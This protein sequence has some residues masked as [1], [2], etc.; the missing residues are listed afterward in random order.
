MRYR[1]LGKSGLRVSELC[2]GTLN[3]GEAK[4]WGVDGTVAH[5]ILTRFADGG[6]TFIDTAP[7]YAGGEA[8]KIVGSFVSADRS[9]YVIATKYTASL[10]DHPLAG[11]NSRK[12]MVRSVDA[13]LERLGSEYIDVLWLHFWDGTTPLEEILRGVDDLVS[14]GKVL[15]FGFSDTPAWLVSRAC[16]IAEWRGWIPP[17]SIQLEYN[18]AARTPERELLPMAEALDLGKVC[19]APLAAG[20]LAGGERRRLLKM[21]QHLATAGSALASISEAAHRS[22]V[23][24]ALGWL[25]ARGCIPLV[26]ARTIDQLDAIISDTAPLD[27]DILL[28]LDSIAEPELG[29]PHTLINSGYLRRFA[30]GDPAKFSPVGRPRI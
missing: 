18:L 9:D 25:R 28:K 24:L 6:G 8:E 12:A 16:T 17:V 30:F 27:E 22:P 15:Y 3:F 5:E 11:G 4:S 13:S 29:F 10:R 14:S 19:W 2:L 20:A 26:G 1:L 23:E 7:N 21:P